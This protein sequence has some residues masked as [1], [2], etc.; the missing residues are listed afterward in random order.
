MDDQT[1]RDDMLTAGAAKLRPGRNLINEELTP[2][3]QIPA[4]AVIIRA[5]WERGSIQA[6]ALAELERRGLW[7]DDAQR[8]QASITD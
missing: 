6:E 3:A 4:Y 5:M 1:E 7:L 2:I 8:R